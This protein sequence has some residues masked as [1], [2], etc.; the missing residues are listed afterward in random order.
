MTVEKEVIFALRARGRL[1]THRIDKVDL[2][3]V[4]ALG[5][6]LSKGL[7]R[8]ISKIHVRGSIMIDHDCSLG[9]SLS[10]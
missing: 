2:L 4:N 1:Q 7:S 10:F 9:A 5:L 8:L 6:I 3:A